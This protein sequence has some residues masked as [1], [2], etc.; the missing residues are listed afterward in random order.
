MSFLLPKELLHPDEQRLLEMAMKGAA[1]AGTPFLSF[2]S[3]EEMPALAAK[4][5]LKNAKI[6]TGDDI[7]ARYFAGREDG[8]KLSNSEMILV[9]N[10]N[11]NDNI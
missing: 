7:T 9:A 3:P 10:A 11:S 2:F 6:V 1:A 5:G 8:V 4:A